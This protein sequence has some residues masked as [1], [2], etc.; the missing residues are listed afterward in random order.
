MPKN[1]RFIK[2][3]R[4]TIRAD[5]LP[6]EVALGRDYLRVVRFIPGGFV[7]DEQ[8]CIGDDVGVEVFF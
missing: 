1:I 3:T 5:Q 2:P 7:V 4:M 8:Q 6:A